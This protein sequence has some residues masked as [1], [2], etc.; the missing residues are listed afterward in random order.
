MLCKTFKDIFAKGSIN[1][2][3]AG[4][5]AV[6]EVRPKLPS[7]ITGREQHPGA[8]RPEHI[9]PQ[10]F[11]RRIQAVAVRPLLLEDSIGHQGAQEAA[12]ALT[13]RANRGRH[14]PASHRPVSEDIGDVKLRGCVERARDAHRKRQVPQHQRR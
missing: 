6:H 12:Q 5:N 13:I 3:S 10:Q 11:G 7:R 9:S 8:L 4:A 14:L 2:G 1:N